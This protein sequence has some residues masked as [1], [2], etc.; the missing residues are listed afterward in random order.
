M[1][2]VDDSEVL[3]W[4]AELEVSLFHAMKGHKPVGVNKNFHMMCIHEKFTLSTGKKCT[5]QHLWDHL[6]TMY[7]LPALHESE[8]LPFPNNEIEFVLPEPEF[9]E[10][11]EAKGRDPDKSGKSKDSVASAGEETPLKSSAK[12]SSIAGGS[13]AANTPDSS[14]KR[15][16]TR[17]TATS[18][19]PGGET[20]T[21]G[22]AKRRRVL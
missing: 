16:R 8:I 3:N 18:S 11:F 1:A 20:P 9:T 4:N 13:S 10:L 15:K 22:S 7:D 17:Q 19:S 14:P 2:S 5:A 12:L 21:T 6:G